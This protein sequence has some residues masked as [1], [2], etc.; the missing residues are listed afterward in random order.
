MRTRAKTR[1]ASDGVKGGVTRTATRTREMHRKRKRGVRGVR[2]GREH[3]RATTRHGDACDAGRVSGCGTWHAA[4]T[5][6]PRGGRSSEPLKWDRS[7]WNARCA[8]GTSGGMRDYD[9][10]LAWRGG[11]RGRVHA[12]GTQAYGDEDG[13]GSSEDERAG[14]MRQRKHGTQNTQQHNTTPHNPL[15]RGSILHHLY[16]AQP[17]SDIR[18]TLHTPVQS[19]WRRS[20][21]EAARENAVGAEGEG[22]LESNQIKSRANTHASEACSPRRRPPAVCSVRA[23]LCA[24][25][26]LSTYCRDASR[27][28]GEGAASSDAGAG[29]FAPRLP[30]ALMYTDWRPA[31]RGALDPRWPFTHVVT[32]RRNCKLP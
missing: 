5:Q 6:R 24:G 14:E 17:P 27:S 25:T 16:T 18:D 30:V 1:E 12:R 32:R 11:G 26:A 7:R 8:D 10:P 20:R 31:T 13:T 19:E 23:W 3:R 9:R 2:S 22:P 28:K 15:N 21:S 29:F 4:G